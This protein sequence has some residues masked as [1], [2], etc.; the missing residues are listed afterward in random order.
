MDRGAWKVGST[1]EPDLL[2][3]IVE[4]GFGVMQKQRP[5]SQGN[6]HVIIQWRKG[7]SPL[8]VLFQASLRCLVKGNESAFAEL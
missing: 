5:S 3:D 8:K 1:R 6:E 7:A 4:C 2:G